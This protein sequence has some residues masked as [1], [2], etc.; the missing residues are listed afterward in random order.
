MRLPQ[1]QEYCSGCGIACMAFLL[2]LDQKRV[3]RLLKINHHDATYRGI[4]CREIVDA[5]K[6]VSVDAE[7]RYLT[8]ALKMKIY[9]DGTIVYI[10]KS[11]SYPVGHYLCR[12]KGRWMDPWINAASDPALQRIKA[13][14]RKRLPGKPQYAVFIDLQ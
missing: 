13:G 12:W 7:L 1:V 9:R 2:N 5:L 14:W 11:T 6:R 3:M 8:P 4:Y 10:A